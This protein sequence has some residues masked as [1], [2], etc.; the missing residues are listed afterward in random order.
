MCS[1]VEELSVR[2]PRLRA[3]KEHGQ[4]LA[5]PPLDEVEALLAVNRRNLNSALFPS[6]GKSLDELR[7][8]ARREIFAA[9]SQYHREAEETVADAAIDVWMV[10]GHQPELFHPGVW[11]KNF[12]V[13]QLGRQHA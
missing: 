10:A 3:P 4:I 11:F 13:H 1:H 7:D 2:L 5:V 12:V 6:I 9:S 8:L